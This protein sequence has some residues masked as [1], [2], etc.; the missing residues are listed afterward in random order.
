MEK[1]GDICKKHGCSHCCNPVRINRLISARFDERSDELPFEKLDEVHI[2]V[3]EL[4]TTR[5]EAYK[6][7]NHDPKTGLCKD[8]INRPD[9]CKNSRCSALDVEDE[10]EQ[11][12]LI[13]EERGQE[14]IVC[15]KEKK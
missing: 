8:Y 1:D 15:K 6:C 9:I 12:K 7:K 5:L 10:D 2:P 14:F 13:Q 3:C 11:R 4:E